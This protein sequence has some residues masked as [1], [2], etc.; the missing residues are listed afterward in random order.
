METLQEYQQKRELEFKIEVREGR[1]REGM[2]RRR[3]KEKRGRRDRKR[4]LEW[5]G[6]E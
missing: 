3:K 5:E 2:K 4:K 6:A 1:P